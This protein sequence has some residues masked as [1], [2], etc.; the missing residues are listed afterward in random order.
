MAK[1]EKTRRKR[2]VNVQKFIML[3]Q[4]QMRERIENFYRDEDTYRQDLEHQGPFDTAEP[5]CD[6][7]TVE[8]MLNFRTNPYYD[9][10]VKFNKIKLQ[11]ALENGAKI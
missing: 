5:A 10:L 9:N 7:Q 11:R 1:F 8:E 3:K 6:F 2:D 4:Q